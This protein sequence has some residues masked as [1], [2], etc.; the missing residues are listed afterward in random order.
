[1]FVSEGHELSHPRNLKVFHGF[2]L[3]AKEMQARV[4]TQGTRRLVGICLRMPCLVTSIATHRPSSKRP[5]QGKGAEKVAQ[6]PVSKRARL[7]MSETEAS[8]G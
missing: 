2:L 3:K 4:E 5:L 8:R 7:D 6:A 1:M